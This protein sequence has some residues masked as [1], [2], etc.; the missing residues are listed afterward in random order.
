MSERTPLSGRE[1]AALQTLFA[2]VSGFTAGI[3]QLEKRSEA[4]ECWEDL[5]EVGRLAQSCLDR[6]LLTV[7]NKKLMQIQT[8]LENVRLHIKIEP[9][10]AISKV[11]GMSYVPTD[12]L[13][14]LLNH[15]CQT[16]CFTCSKTAVEAR[17]CPHRK[18]IED[19]L[20]HE[21]EGK[22]RES[23]RFSDMVLGLEV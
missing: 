6:L 19:A 20:P 1:Y 10:W 22:E 23:C 15:M 17:K 9:N 12:T 21:V 13:N 4:A 7:P 18:T 5:Q 11:R 16:E 3:D 8:E 14:D 2:M